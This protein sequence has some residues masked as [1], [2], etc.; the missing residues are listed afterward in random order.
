M[1]TGLRIV[2]ATIL[3][4]GVFLMVVGASWHIESVGVTGL[5][6][7]FLGGVGSVANWLMDRSAASSPS[8]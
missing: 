1:E 8:P 5:I 6:A 4:V 3:I 7:V 2:L